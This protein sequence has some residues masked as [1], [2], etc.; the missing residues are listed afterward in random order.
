MDALALGHV[1]Q[2]GG[3]RGKDRIEAKRLGHGHRHIGG[4]LE[5]VAAVEGKVLQNGQDE[6][7]EVR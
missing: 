2:P 3:H 7:D 4:R 6:G 5:G 1:A